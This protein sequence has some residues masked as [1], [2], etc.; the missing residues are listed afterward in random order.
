MS[1]EELK[2]YKEELEALNR[3]FDRSTRPHVRQT[4]ATRFLQVFTNFVQDLEGEE[5]E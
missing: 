4:L 2:A 1:L 5:N 3:S